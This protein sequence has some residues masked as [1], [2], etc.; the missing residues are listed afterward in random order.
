[1]IEKPRYFRAMGVYKED[2]KIVRQSKTGRSPLLDTA[3]QNM[4]G[5]L[6]NRGILVSDSLDLEGAGDKVYLITSGTVNIR[7][8][9]GSATFHGPCDDATFS[10]ETLAREFDSCE[11]EITS[12]EESFSRNLLEEILGAVND[13]SFTQKVER[14]YK[15]L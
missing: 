4:Y 9:L 8:V 15:E 14:E 2:P 12:G 1:M 7:R 5:Y 13:E 3:T 11:V 6:E 10:D